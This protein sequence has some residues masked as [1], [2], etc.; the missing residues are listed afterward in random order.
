MTYTITCPIAEGFIQDTCDR[1]GQDYNSKQHS[2][3][4]YQ[5]FLMKLYKA[6]YST[7]SLCPD[8]INLGKEGLGSRLLYSLMLLFFV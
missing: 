1:K 5:G 3:I 4:D 7:A 2:V 8:F 6:L